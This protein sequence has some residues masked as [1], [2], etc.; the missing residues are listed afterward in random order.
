MVLSYCFLYVC[1]CF[2]VSIT[3]LILGSQSN[4][5]K[6]R[7]RIVEY[8][9]GVLQEYHRGIKGSDWFCKSVCVNFSFYSTVTENLS[10][11]LVA[12]VSSVPQFEADIP[13]MRTPVSE[14]TPMNERLAKYMGRIHAIAAA[15][16]FDVNVCTLGYHPAAANIELRWEFICISPDYNPTLNVANTV[17]DQT[18]HSIFLYYSE[19]ELPGYSLASHYQVIYDKKE[20]QNHPA[21]SWANNL[22]PAVTLSYSFFSTLVR[23]PKWTHY[24]FSFT[25][26]FKKLVLHNHISRTD[27]FCRIKR[28][29]MKK[30][31]FQHQNVLF[32][33]PTFSLFLKLFSLIKFP[34]CIK[35]RLF[36][37]VYLAHVLKILAFCGGF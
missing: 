1:S 13:R 4:H 19:S 17:Q 5:I 26:T 37:S 8:L 6:I 16:M 18:K 2:F 36:S 30:F 22:F 11:H 33:N 28:K 32:S 27:L 14:E 20:T 15:K 9:D 31:S 35:F 24:I 34:I 25:P 3:F 12:A 10:V 7:S 29:I 21:A 23:T